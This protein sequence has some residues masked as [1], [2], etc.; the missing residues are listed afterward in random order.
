MADL[1]CSGPDIGVCAEV[2]KEWPRMY[3]SKTG[4]LVQGLTHLPGHIVPEVTRA[5]GKP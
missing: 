1:E 2:R 3:K 4:D 5:V